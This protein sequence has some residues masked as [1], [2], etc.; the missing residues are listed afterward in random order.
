MRTRSSSGV[1]GR[2][3]S[4]S[5][6][7]VL[8]DRITGAGAPLFPLAWTGRF[9]V[10]VQQATPAQRAATTLHLKTTQGGGVQR[11]S[12][13][14]SPIGP[15]LDQGRVVRRCSAWH[16]DMAVDLRPG[17]LSGVEG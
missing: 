3:P 2:P 13:L 8:G 10:D 12:D 17:A 7:S 14:A 6:Q 11:G 4:G 5:H 15:V 9:T 1:P 16:Q